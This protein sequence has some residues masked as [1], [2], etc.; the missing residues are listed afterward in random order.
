M[1][2][3][4]VE[5]WDLHVLY[6][7]SIRASMAE[8]YPKSSLMESFV[9][10]GG[11]LSM[12]YDIRS[13]LR[14]SYYFGFLRHICDDKFKL[15]VNA[16][17]KVG[18]YGSVSDPCR[19]C[20]PTWLQ[21]SQPYSNVNIDVAQD[22]LLGSEYTFR[23]SS[24]SNSY[25]VQSC[26][27]LRR[28]VTSLASGC[29]DLKEIDKLLITVCLL[30]STEESDT[31]HSGNIQQQNNPTSPQPQQNHNPI[32][33]NYPTGLREVLPTENLIESL[34]PTHLP[35]SF[36]SYKSHLPQTNNQL[37][38]SSNAKELKLLVQVTKVMVQDASLKEDNKCDKS[39]GK[40]IQR[41]E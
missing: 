36:R 13:T 17:S 12:P 25:Q 15:E 5:E 14:I 30:I 32:L 6:V 29:E 8:T 28:R 24:P 11:F 41:N 34:Y 26:L 35:S 18:L 31:P 1:F 21:T 39:K 10:F 37:R 27:S 2:P 7:D 19:S 16:I 20:L 33:D 23:T 38:A 40:T 3:R 4:V 22:G 9:P